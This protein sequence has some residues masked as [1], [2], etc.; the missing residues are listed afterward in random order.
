MQILRIPLLAGI[1]L[2]TAALFGCGES[3]SWYDY[4]NG[5]INLNV[6]SII[7]PVIDYKLTLSTDDVN[8]IGQDY[9]E[10]MTDESIDKILSILTAEEISKQN[11]YRIKF[12]IYVMF[13]TF[14]LS[15][16]ESE[17]YIKRPTNYQVNDYLLSELKKQ[18]ANADIIATVSALK[19]QVFPTSDAF[20]EA[21]SGTGNLNMDNWWVANTLPNLGLGEAGSKFSNQLPGTKLET[22][23]AEE[24]LSKLRD[25]IK[26]ALKSYKNIP[27]K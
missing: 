15:L 21:L 1:F 23:L 16:L 24:P 18:G 20:K 4:G 17:D 26:S 9:S 19:G 10:P 7:K 11:F 27:A 3:S 12:N 2:A 14:K 25:G 6:V 5:K 13:D 22:P 8:D